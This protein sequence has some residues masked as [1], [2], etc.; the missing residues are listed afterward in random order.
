MNPRARVNLILSALFLWCCW[1]LLGYTELLSTNNEGH[2]NFLAQRQNS[3]AASDRRNIGSSIESS[4]E[5]TT[6]ARFQNSSLVIIMG[7]L[8]GGEQ[9]WQSLY[10]NVL[11]VNSGDLALIIGEEQKQQSKQDA[12]DDEQLSYPYNSSLYKR[13]KYIWTFPEYED[14][15]DAIDLIFT[16]NTATTT[17]SSNSSESQSWRETHL[18]QFTKKRTG[19][20]GGV[21]GYYGSGAIIFMIRW[22]LSQRLVEHS[23]PDDVTILNQYERFVLTRAD[24]YY[25]CPH[26]YQTLDLSNNTMWIPQGEA[27]GGYT[28]RHLIV[29]RD[30]I[31]DALDIFPTLFQ[32]TNQQLQ[33]WIAVGTPESILKRVW[34]S[35]GLHVRTMK[36]VMFTCATLFDTSRWKQ[37]KGDVPGVPGLLKKYESEYN[38]TQVNCPLS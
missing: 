25:Q 37:P 33:D 19:L 34:T 11:D 17:N 14:W 30:N 6:P 38:Q 13:A 31:L 4:V 32:Q 36:R 24:H 10:K 29:S 8:R 5:T 21:K 22:F 7:N 12:A 20:L 15:A 26:D 16:Y 9:A 35:K 3:I 23:R 27:Y 28:D 1:Q 18:P 2:L